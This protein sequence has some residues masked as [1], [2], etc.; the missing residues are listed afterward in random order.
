MTFLERKPGNS[1]DWPK[2]PDVDHVTADNI[3]AGPIKLSGPP[4]FTITGGEN[5]MKKFNAFKKQ[6]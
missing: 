3:I 5:A 1:Y 6:K 2:N 4:P